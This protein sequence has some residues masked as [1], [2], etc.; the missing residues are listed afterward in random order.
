MQIATKNNNSRVHWYFLPELVS[1]IGLFTTD[2]TVVS[3]SSQARLIIS[4][5]NQKKS[6]M[7]IRNQVSREIH[8]ISLGFLNMVVHSY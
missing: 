2:G 4:N 3:I 1:C 5:L 7:R 6:L 8:A